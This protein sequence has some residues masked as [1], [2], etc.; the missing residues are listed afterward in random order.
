MV[1]RV[2]EG[3]LAWLVT[4]LSAR[5]MAKWKTPPTGAMLS[6]S[7]TICSASSGTPTSSVVTRNYISEDSRLSVALLDLTYTLG[8]GCTELYRMSALIVESERVG[9]RE[10][11][12]MH[13]PP[14]FPLSFTHAHTSHPSLVGLPS[15]PRSDRWFNAGNGLACKAN[16]ENGEVDGDG[17]GRTLMP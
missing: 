3:V 2:L 4:S 1:N 11:G 14:P 5:Y 9:G 15:V 6:A 12:G 17:T 8:K 7:C 16:L 10:G 13:Y